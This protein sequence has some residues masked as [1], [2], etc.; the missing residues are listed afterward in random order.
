[1]SLPL[2]PT[3]TLDRIR[4]NLVG[5]KM[6]RALEVLDQTVR[7]IERGEI[8][9]LDA[10]DTLLTEELTLRQNRRVILDD[11]PDHG[12]EDACRLRLRF[13]AP[14]RSQSDPHAGSARLH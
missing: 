4:R 12:G 9:A 3:S 5:L 11:G 13:P 7:L 10:I 6:A 14:A 8:T 2:E 1:M